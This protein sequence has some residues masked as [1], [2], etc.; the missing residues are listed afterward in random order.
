MRI[1]TALQAAALL[2]D[3]MTVA[4]SGFGGCCH[5]E[6]ITAA[7]E[8][9]FL[10]E[11]A[12][13]GLTLLFAASTGD[14]KTRGMD[15]FG[16]EG[17]V[18]RVIAGGW[19]GTPRLGEL[20]LAEKIEAHCWPQGVIAQLY[21]AIAAGQPGIVTRIG[22][23]SF[24]DPLH[25]G[26]RMNA[27]TPAPLV[28][29]VRLRGQDWLLYPAL[30]LD[31]VLLRGTT[32][33]EDGNVTTEDEAFPLDLLAMA[34]A[35]RNS[36]GLVIVQVKRIARRGS[37][38][39]HAVRVP[40]HLVDHVVVCTDP[41]LHGITFGEADNAAFAGRLRVPDERAVLPLSVDKVIQRRA[42]L[43]MAGL[44]HPTINLGIGI[45]AGIGRVAAEEGFTAYTMTVESGVVGGIPGEELA[46]GAAANPTA[47]VPQA[48][49]FDFYDGGG[50]DI[51]FLGMAEADVRG[52]VNVSR[53][54]RQV[55]GV[56]GF[57]NIAQSARRVVYV[58]AFTAGGAD[59]AVGERG[60][61]IR[62]DGRTCKIVERVA[63]V[64]ADPAAA[65]PGQEQ[66]IVTERA[67][68]RVRDS[69]LTLTEVA[70][71]IDARTHVLERLP[72]G[73]AVAEPLGTM[74]GKLFAERPMREAGP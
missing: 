63:Q 23:G 38:D 12:P 55:V 20:A 46:F 25:G 52:A 34:Q 18:A 73:I 69:R 44:D 17:L 58:G 40:G 8:A 7:V 59:I 11:G 53:F 10:A 61:A 32:A 36:G 72:P 71:G 35:G 54:G 48:S 49:Q 22:L 4:A 21:R 60:L 39:P 31:C 67:V 15:H 56:G 6:A 74:P 27:S 62:A 19:R 5:P 16:H 43:E 30:A 1:L 29:R 51:A 66:A 3:S 24:M 26:G 65:P 64:S 45:P 33:D 50:L 9:R 47:V 28:E 57:T 70:P 14:R 68:F 41:A 2:R 13:R 37:L 42:F